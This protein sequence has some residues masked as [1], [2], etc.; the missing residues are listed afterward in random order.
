MMSGPRYLHKEEVC[1]SIHSPSDDH[2]HTRYFL[3]SVQV[4]LVVRLD[5]PSSW[6]AYLC[7]SPLGIGHL[8]PIRGHLLSWG[9]I[10]TIKGVS[11]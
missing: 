1:I 8:F 7:P 2:C 10:L 5:A 9:H 4:F 6:V 11:I 3:C